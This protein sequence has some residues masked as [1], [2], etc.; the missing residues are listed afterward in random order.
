VPLRA[1]AKGGPIG[2][3]LD[4]ILERMGARTEAGVSEYAGDGTIDL[5]VLGGG[6]T[7]PTKVDNYSSSPTGRHVEL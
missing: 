1:A 2:P 7:S 4:T 5:S 6:G 3:I